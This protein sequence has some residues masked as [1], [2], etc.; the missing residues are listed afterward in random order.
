[1]GRQFDVTVPHRLSRDEALTRIKT[2]MAQLKAQHGSQVSEISESWQGNRCDFS[3]KVK[4]FRISGSIVVGD[5]TAEIRGTM[6]PGTGRY[7]DKA[8]A[9]IADRARSLLA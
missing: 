1:M 5:S 7:A 6:P 4:I 8:Q 2:L 3:L 9:M